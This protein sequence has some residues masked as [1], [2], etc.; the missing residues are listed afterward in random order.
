TFGD[1]NLAANYFLCGLLVMRAIRRPRHALRRWICCALIVT[2]LCL[3]LS[4]G[5][6]LALIIA[7]VLGWLFGLARRVGGRRAV[8]TAV[9]VLIVSGVLVK[10][11]D[12]R[13]WVVV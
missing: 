8:V 7:T 9:L 6:L 10:T 13:G 11:V 3:T 12:V 1:P 5:G 2:A 4:N